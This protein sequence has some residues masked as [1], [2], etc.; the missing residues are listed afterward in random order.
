MSRG[1]SPKR[2]SFLGVVTWNAAS[3]K[4]VNAEVRRA[5]KDVLTKLVKKFQ[6]ICLQEV[7]GGPEELAVWFPWLAA[8]FYLYGSAGV[9]EATAGTVICLAKSLVKPGDQIVER[10]PVLGRA[11]RVEVRG[12]D[13][14]MIGWSVHNHGLSAQEASEVARQIR[15]DYDRAN[16]VTWLGGDWNFLPE[17]EEDFDPAEAGGS[18]ANVSSRVHE[19]L[20]RRS[21]GNFLDLGTVE[22]THRCIAQGTYARLDRVYTSLREWQVVNSVV[23]AKPTQ[24]VMQL[25]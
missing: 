8:R 13:G 6:I 17:G 11:V 20:F 23:T 2:F 4:H 21:L 19:G 1:G 14:G 22:P 9:N 24:D 25:K 3:L 5:R 16:T 10:V 15:A 12:E 7:H 18:R